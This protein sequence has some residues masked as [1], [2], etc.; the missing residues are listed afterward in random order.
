[1]FGQ[2][3]TLLLIMALAVLLGGLVKGLVGIGLPIVSV[4][5]LSS[6]IDVRLA[7]GTLVI[8]IVLTNLWQAVHTGRPL[9]TI[10]RF[11]PLIVAMM[12]C[13]WLGAV[14][15][16]RLPGDLLYGLIG[17]V[18]VVFTAINLFTPHWTLPARH[19]RWS[20]VLAG[21]MSGLLGGISTIWGPPL[22]MYFVMIRLPKDTFI[23]VVGLIWFAASIPL[24][25]GYIRNGILDLPTAK[26][27]A[28]ACLPGFAGMWLGTWLRGHFDQETFRKVLLVV[29]LLIG[30]NLIRRALF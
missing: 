9:E 18:V 24:L 5:V 21:A 20:G 8:P 30:L 16:V 28:A 7:L 17:A 27:S 12:I 10:R 13:I 4:A 1:M 2:D 25:L 11:W 23:R 3:P 19:E 29:L 22:V 26:L 6:V 15:V 14:L